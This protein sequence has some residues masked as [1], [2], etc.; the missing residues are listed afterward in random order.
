MPSKFTY[1]RDHVSSSRATVLHSEH[2]GTGTCGLRIVDVF[3]RDK[4]SI[5]WHTADWVHT[6]LR[7]EFVMLEA[8][9]EHKQMN[10]IL[11]PIMRVQGFAYILPQ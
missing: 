11:D 10:R 8:F 7:Q 9:V 6:E 1:C 3:E 4:A 5:G 2:R